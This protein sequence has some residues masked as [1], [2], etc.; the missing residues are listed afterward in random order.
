M[1]FV[2]QPPDNH[3][4]NHSAMPHPAFKGEEQLKENKSAI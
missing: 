1:Y 4:Y 3:Y 2:S